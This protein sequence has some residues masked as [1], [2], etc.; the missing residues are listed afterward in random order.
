M[1]LT[2]AGVVPPGHRN[3]LLGIGSF[4]VM[5]EVGAGYASTSTLF[6]NYWAVHTG[7][8][9]VDPVWLTGVVYADQDQ[10]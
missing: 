1:R 9:D 2:D 4:E 5:R 6:R 10:N 3:H 8:R 7:F